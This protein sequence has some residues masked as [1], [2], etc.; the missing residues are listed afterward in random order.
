MLRRKAGLVLP[1]DMLPYDLTVSHWDNVTCGVSYIADD[2]TCRRNIGVVTEQTAVR[3]QSGS[4]LSAMSTV[5][6]GR[7]SVLLG[8]SSQARRLTS[9]PEV[10]LEFPFFKY[11]LIIR[12]C[13]V[14]EVEVR[15]SDQQR[16]L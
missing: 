16:G 8:F 15:L 3:Y 1:L 10:T 14:R 13:Y 7:P 5:R 11:H 9:T 6:E 4:W 2:H 12:L